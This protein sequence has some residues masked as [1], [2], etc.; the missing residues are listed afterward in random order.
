MQSPTA[1]ESLS[2]GRRIIGQFRTVRSPSVRHVTLQLGHYQSIWT[3]WLFSNQRLLSRADYRCV[4]L[5]VSELYAK[6][7]FRLADKLVDE[8]EHSIEMQLPYLRKICEG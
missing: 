4:Y 7:G 2:L 8:R 3:V 1:G 5:V 6:G